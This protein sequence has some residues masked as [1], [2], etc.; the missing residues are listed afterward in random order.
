MN[1]RALYTIAL[2]AI[3]L[4]SC[5]TN[6][7][8]SKKESLI[9]A[10]EDS[11][12]G[13]FNF[14]GAQYGYMADIIKYYC[15]SDSI[16]LIIKTYK[17]REQVAEAL[18]DGTADIGLLVG[19]QE[20]QD[21]LKD[22][23]IEYKQQFV[24][25]SKKYGKIAN[26]SEFWRDVAGKDISIS[27][28]FQ[29]SQL[30]E[31]LQDTN[32]N[33]ELLSEDSLLIHGSARALAFGVAD[34]TITTD[35]NAR[36]FTFLFRNFKYVYQVPESISSRLEV[37]KKNQ[38]LYK[39]FSKWY[40]REFQFSPQFEYNRELY[41]TN[42]F[43]QE[44]SQ[45]GYLTLWGAFSPY[46]KIFKE[47][48]Q[49]SGFAWEFLCAIGYVESRFGNL[50]QSN[51]GA[52]GLMQ[53]MPKVARDYGFN[54]DS[55]SDPRYNIE[56]AAHILEQNCKMLGFDKDSLDWDKSSILL[57]CYNAG[58]GRIADGRRVTKSVGGDPNNWLN[59]RQGLY[60]LRDREFIRDNPL[61]KH[62]YFRSAA[63]GRYAKD[64][65]ERFA[66]YQQQNTQN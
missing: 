42:K 2:A 12:P 25:L 45:S 43:V 60:M 34:Y 5:S 29:K 57:A 13:I 66:L 26:Q 62:G 17:N 24:M 4:F 22:F 21:G 10:V 56:V 38:K 19:D 52:I 3:L 44:L 28:S 53:I 48:A 20:T 30:F 7:S 1:I 59:L 41:S 65:M 15:K 16:S 61:I 50:R 35:Q 58:Y 51:A 39:S 11:A 47:V 14:Q 27:E 64:V 37:H 49:E 54:T 8:S 32:L 55:L 36:L 40:F 33:V 6:N 31:Q 63:T 46:D 23:G 18:A 9:L